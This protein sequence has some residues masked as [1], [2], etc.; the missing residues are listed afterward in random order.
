MNFRKGPSRPDDIAVIIG[1]ADYGRTGGA[2]PDVTPAYSDAAGIKRYVTEALG[3][4]EDN[5]IFVKAATQAVMTTTFGAPGNPRGMLYN[6]VEPGESHVFVYYS[7]HGAPA[8][9]E[10]SAYLVPTDA[11][12]STIEHNSYPLSTLYANLAKIPAKSV[13][14]VLEAC[15]SGASQAG[16]VISNASPVFLKARTAAVPPNITVIGAGTANQMASWE[17]D[18][19]HGLFTKY[20]LL[21]MAGAADA[22]PYG[23][24]DGTVSYAELKRYFKKTVTKFARRYYGRDQ[25]AQIVVGR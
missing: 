13:T 22:A 19:S 12:P 23:N 4:S 7:G 24:G 10:G 20:Y 1:N 17:K 25:T 14:V 8:G 21:G 3:I 5:I 18:K 9:A 15:F 11:N 16:A 2:I 6:W